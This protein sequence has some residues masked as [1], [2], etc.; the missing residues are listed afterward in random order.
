[1]MLT[2]ACS[3]SREERWECER[4]VDGG[5]AV[6]LMR[7]GSVRDA[8]ESRFVCHGVNRSMPASI[9]LMTP[10]DIPVI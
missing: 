10:C 4:K 9:K 3:R 2:S 7:I 5:R 8:V 1:V 6:L